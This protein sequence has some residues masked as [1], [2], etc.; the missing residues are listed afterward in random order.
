MSGRRRRG[1]RALAQNPRAMGTNP[2]ALASGEAKAKRLAALPYDAYLRTEHWRKLRLVVLD[3]WGGYCEGCGVRP[4]VQVHHKTY[5]RLGREELADLTP[6]CAT[7]HAG[8]HGLT[9]AL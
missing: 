1:K 4:A 3:R 7:C 5:E 8:E 2:R 6:L 9:V